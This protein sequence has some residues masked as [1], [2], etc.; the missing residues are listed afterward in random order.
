MCYQDLV[1]PCYP[2]MTGVILAG[3]QSH[4]MGGR[5]KAFLP[6]GGRR[7]IE[8]LTELFCRLFGRVI[9]VASQP[10]LF[11]D[12]PVAVARDLVPNQG[13]IMGLITGLF[14]APT[15]WV[16]VSA[17]DTPLLTKE[18]VGL[19]VG[20]I[21]SKVKAV[22]P[23]SPAGFFPLSA[24]YH[25]GCLAQLRR[26]YDQGQRAIRPLFALVPVRYLDQAEVARVDPEGL[27]LFNV[28][29]PAD[30]AGLEALAARLCLF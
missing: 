26:V 18:M 28:N 10:A 7:F 15:D 14:Y 5:T 12:L 8:H 16:L 1:A 11:A 22:I 25:R 17:C 13:P 3:G 30:L 29:T 24:A 4:R 19:M 23:R 2:E 9:I 20:A 21:D 6:L 27:S